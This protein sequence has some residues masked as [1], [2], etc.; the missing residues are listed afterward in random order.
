[1]HQMGYRVSSAPKRGEDPSGFKDPYNRQL[2]VSIG[3]QWIVNKLGGLRTALASER[4]TRNDINTIWDDRALNQAYQV[5]G[6]MPLVTLEA[7]N[8]VLPE[9]LKKR[10]SKMIT[11]GA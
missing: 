5:F 3:N 4:L 8:D 6:G 9:G 10:L 1:M 2:A 7:A 11:V